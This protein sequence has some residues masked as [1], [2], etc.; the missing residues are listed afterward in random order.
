MSKIFVES[1]I[2]NKNH[3][4]DLHPHGLPPPPIKPPAAAAEL[5]RRRRTAATAA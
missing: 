2:V 4:Q 3:H 5:C 1:Y